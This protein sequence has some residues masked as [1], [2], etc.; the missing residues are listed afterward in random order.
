MGAGCGYR[1]Q[2]STNDRRQHDRQHQRRPNVQKVQ[3][4]QNGG[5]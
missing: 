5:K 2:D 3:K 1:V 4:V